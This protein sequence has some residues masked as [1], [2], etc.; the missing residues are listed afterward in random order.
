M[1]YYVLYI[2]YYI[3]YIVYSITYYTLCIKY[4]THAN[5]A[6]TCNIIYTYI[7]LY[8]HEITDIIQIKLD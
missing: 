7:Q 1:I 2:K 5:R 6:H 3:L 8:T 4:I